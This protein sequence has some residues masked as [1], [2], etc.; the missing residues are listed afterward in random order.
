MRPVRARLLLWTAMQPLREITLQS[1][2]HVIWSSVHWIPT[3]DTLLADILSFGQFAKIA[4]LCPHFSKPEPPSPRMTR[5]H[6]H[7]FADY[8]HS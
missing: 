6:L 3:S 2:L 4:D 1:A 8:L 5:R 7:S